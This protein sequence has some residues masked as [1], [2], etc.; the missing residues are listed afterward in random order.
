M[1]VGKI[2]E[3]G[4]KHRI[5]LEFGIQEVYDNFKQNSQVAYR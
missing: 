4:W 1:D 5:A 3:M 2:N